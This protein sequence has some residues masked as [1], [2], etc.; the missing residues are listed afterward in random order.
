MYMSS[1]ALL[2]QVINS[3]AGIYGNRSTI[4]H[5]T[6]AINERVTKLRNAFRRKHDPCGMTKGNIAN[7]VARFSQISF[8]LA[9]RSKWS[10]PR[11]Y[12]MDGRALKWRL[13]ALVRQGSILSEN[14]IF[15]V[16]SPSVSSRFTIAKSVGLDN[17]GRI[18]V[19]TRPLEI[20][21]TQT[22]FCDTFPF[23][24]R[25]ACIRI[26]LSA[27]YRFDTCR[28]RDEV[29]EPLRKV[30]SARTDVAR[31]NSVTNLYFHAK[32][33]WQRE[34][35][36]RGW[37]SSQM[38][39]HYL[40]HTATMNILRRKSA[41]TAAGTRGIA[42]ERRVASSRPSRWI[43]R[44]SFLLIVRTISESRM[45]KAAHSSFW[46]GDAQISSRFFSFPV[47]PSLSF[48]RSPR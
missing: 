44:V 37:P 12:K 48:R 4:T 43:S 14:C 34:I 47:I 42:N 1:F 41:T 29:V 46:A 36:P 3:D 8:T 20:S 31:K 15:R 30:L 23:S 2:I 7:L 24:S 21:R 26:G 18:S 27:R 10:S 33:S 25:V 5:S 13:I 16:G 40:N 19:H 45:D 39:L 32:D 9:P 6:N 38:S 28:K 11:D 17:F 22:F 35:V